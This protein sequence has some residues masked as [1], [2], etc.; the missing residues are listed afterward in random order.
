MSSSIP[1]NI[2]SV[3]SS[4][5]GSSAGSSTM[6]ELSFALISARFVFNELISSLRL[7][8]SATICW[9]SDELTES[10]ATVSPEAMPEL[11]VTGCSG[12][13]GAASDL[14][15]FTIGAE[16]ILSLSTERS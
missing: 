2:S 7:E 8:R 5:E 6:P 9:R 12:A 15:S 16:D 11:S 14:I 4:I 1:S 13:A 10:T 3:L